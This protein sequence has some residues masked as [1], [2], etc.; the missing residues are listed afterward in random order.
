[1]KVNYAKRALNTCSN[2]Q[3]NKQ[4]T[5]F[6]IIIIIIILNKSHSK[7]GSSVSPLLCES[8]LQLGRRRPTITTTDHWPL[9]DCRV[10]HWHG[11]GMLHHP[12]CKDAGQSTAAEFYYCICSLWCKAKLTSATKLKQNWNETKTKQ[13][14]KLKINVPTSAM[15]VKQNQNNSKTI[16]KS[17]N[18]LLSL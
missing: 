8:F 4:Q 16:P 18:G 10:Q 9:A 13:K 2:L 15:K 12:R 6:I 7:Y 11:N 1:M 14:Q 5:K 17:L 3:V